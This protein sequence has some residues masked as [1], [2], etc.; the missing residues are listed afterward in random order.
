MYIFA[1]EG[2]IRAGIVSFRYGAEQAARWSAGSGDRQLSCVMRC[3]MVVRHLRHGTESLLPFCRADP[4]T[5]RP[6]DPPIHRFTDSPI[7]RFTDSPI[8]RQRCGLLVPVGNTP[9]HVEIDRY[10]AWR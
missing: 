6:I 5:H 8:H 4:P 10:P 1:V 9:M 7:H 2:D 3:S